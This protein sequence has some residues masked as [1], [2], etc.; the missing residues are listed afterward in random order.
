MLVSG[1]VSALNLDQFN[2]AYNL[3]LTTMSFLLV[4]RLNRAAVRFWS[5]RQMWGKLVE[6]VRQLACCA[7]THLA[8]APVQRDAV[9][10]WACAFAVASKDFLRGHA[11]VDAEELSGILKPADCAL[12]SASPHPPLFCASA[13]RTALTAALGPECV[14]LD[15]ER[16]AARNGAPADAAADLRFVVAASTHR[17]AVMRVMETHIDEL[18]GCTGGMERIKAT[19]LPVVYVSHLRTFLLGYLL[20]MPVVYLHVWRWGTF[21]V[22]MLVSFALLGVEGAATECESP[23]GDRCNHLAMDRYAATAVANVQ[24]VLRAA[25]V[26]AQMSWAQL[27][28]RQSG[29]PASPRQL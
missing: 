10:A 20:L 3:V 25:D 1:R 22:M 27:G 18:V 28:P 7:A 5:T 24:E 17:S 4:F 29:V 16:H 26:H 19:P 2:S 6:V 11:N 12:A 14:L 23:F 15:A 8:H 13:M 21:P 9:C